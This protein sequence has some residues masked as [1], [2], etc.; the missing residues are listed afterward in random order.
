LIEKIQ[1][2]CNQS[3]SSYIFFSYQKKITKIC[4]KKRWRKALKVI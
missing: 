3:L 4:S 1:V 2:S